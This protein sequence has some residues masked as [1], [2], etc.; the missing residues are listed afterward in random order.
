M[1]DGLRAFGDGAP[2]VR[3]VDDAVA[4]GRSPDNRLPEDRFDRQPLLHGDRFLLVADIRLDNRAELGAALGIDASDA[5]SSCDADLLLGAWARWQEGALD[6]LIGDYAIAIFDRHNKRLLLARDPIGQRPLFFVR[7]GR[8]VGFASMPSGLLACAQFRRGLGIDRLAA[9]LVGQG[10]G[11]TE[12]YFDGIERVLPGQL[13]E[14]SADSISHRFFWN[15]PCGSIRLSDD[16]AIEAYREHLERAVRAQS[17]RASGLLGAQLSSGF[18]SSAVAATAA[19]LEP[20]QS[21][22]AFTAAPRADFSGPVPRGRIGDE[23]MLA[24]LTA[25]RHHMRHEIV[26]PTSGL[27]SHLREQSLLYQEPDRNIINM[28]WWSESNARARSL[29]V[30][31]MLTGQMGNLTL[32]AGG[33]PILA[34]WLRQ[35]GLRDWWHEARAAHRGLDVRWRGILYATFERHIPDVGQKLLDRVFFNAPTLAEQSFVRPE[36]LAV[37]AR[38]RASRPFANRYEAIAENDIGVFRKGALAEHGI[39]ERDPTADRRLVEFSLRLPL[40]QMLHRGVSRPLARR[41][42]ADRVPAEVLNSP[43][44][45]YQGADWYERFDRAEAGGL[46]EDIASSPIANDL[47]DIPKMKQTLDHWPHSGAA[48]PRSRAIFRTRL[49]IAISTGIFIQSF[50]PLLAG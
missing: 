44:R 37:A 19:M 7:T 18:D 43:L 10:Q 17:R 50:E 15:P 47:L 1:L 45:G 42:L 12:T 49:T 34:E 24:A 38:R 22:I 9:M 29:G 23:S 28:E 32:N 20:G 41:A 33:L 4:F 46:I 39:D 30:S 13:V 36:W 35:R 40:E 21:L 25:Q 48:D 3:S 2:D 6:R 16:D 5:R 31:T 11:A 14:I 8:A 27:F 26:R